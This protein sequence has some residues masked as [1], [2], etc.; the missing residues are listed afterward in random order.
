MACLETAPLLL[1]MATACPECRRLIWLQATDKN[2]KR[3]KK[4]TDT[5]QFRLWQAQDWR[6]W[7]ACHQ[8][9]IARLRRPR[10]R[11]CHHRP[12]LRLLWHL[13]HRARSEEHR[14]QQEVQVLQGRHLRPRCCTWVIHPCI[15]LLSNKK[16]FFSQK[17]NMFLIRMLETFF[18]I[19][20]SLKAFYLFIIIPFHDFT[21]SFFIIND[22]HLFCFSVILLVLA[23]IIY[24]VSFSKDLAKGEQF[25]L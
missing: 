22:W 7:I 20:C 17:E 2:D 5:L 1:S 21:C 10:G 13:P 6:K 12:D 25:H 18:Y 23:A 4:D 3:T 11:L 24:P 16:N 8:I 14:P 15:N 9:Q 19:R